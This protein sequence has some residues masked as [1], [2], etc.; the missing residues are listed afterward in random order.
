MAV[1]TKEYR[2]LDYSMLTFAKEIT[3][4]EDALKD[5]AP[6]SPSTKIEVTKAEKDFDNKC[7]KLEIS[8]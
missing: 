8:Y 3:H 2:K 5:I 4:M 1:K 6:V 7:V